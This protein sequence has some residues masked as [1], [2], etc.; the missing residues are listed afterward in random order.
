MDPV[1][2]ATLREH[3]RWTLA[4]ALIGNRARCRSSARGS[5]TAGTVAVGW[6]MAGEDGGRSRRSL[7]R[8][9]TIGFQTLIILGA[10]A[11]LIRLLH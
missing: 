8:V 10:V 9:G 4:A 1:G 11:A 2:R 3:R 5:A 7:P 6:G